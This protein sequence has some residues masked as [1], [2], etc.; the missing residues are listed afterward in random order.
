MISNP[1]KYIAFIDECGDHSLEKIDID[2]PIFTLSIIII[3]RSYYVE[4]L[5]PLFAKFKLKFWNHEGVNLHSRDIRNSLGDFNFLQV[6]DLRK[7]FF[8]DL[9]CLISNMSFKIFASVINK[10]L[11]KKR[12]KEGLVNPYNLAIGSIFKQLESFLKQRRE[13][14]LPIIVE[15]RGK[16]EDGQLRSFFYDVESLRVD[17]NLNFLLSF[18]KKGENISGMQIAD[19]CAYPIA[20]KYLNPEKENRSFEIISKNIITNEVIE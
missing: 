4:H 6:P 17:K 3:E 5:I 19:L 15:S 1:S 18:H 16:R 11:Y 2:F 13:T 12:Q 7:M 20:R 8:N 9:E 10:E 14:S